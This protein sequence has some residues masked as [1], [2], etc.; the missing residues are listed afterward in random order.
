MPSSD[1]AALEGDRLLGPESESESECHSTSLFFRIAA[2]MFSFTVLGMMVST[3]GVMV[4]QF[5][6]YYHL[7]DLGVSFVFLV[8]PVGYV[9]AAY[10]NGAIHL[11]CGQRGIAAIGPL[12]HI[13]FTAAAVA[14]ALHPS[15]PVLLV[16]LATGSLGTGILD[17]SFC[18]WA[19]GMENANIVQGLL[20][21]S[22]SAGAAVGPFLAG[23]V[24][25]VGHLPWYTWYYV[26]LGASILEAV[27]LLLAFR[28]EDSEKCRNDHQQDRLLET[29]AETRPDTKTAIFKHSVTWI[30]A[31]YFLAYVGTENAISGWI[32]VFMQRVNHAS[33]YLASLSSSGFWIGQAAGRLVLGVV[34]DRIGVR[35]ATTVYLIAALAFELLFAAVHVPAVS[36]VTIALLGFCL[37]PLFPAGIFM[38]TRLLPRELH[39]EAISFVVLLGQIGGALLPFALG[40]LANTLGIRVFQVVVFAQLVATLLIWF[41]F[42]R[43]P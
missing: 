13:T 34:T 41:A 30:C 15:F 37:G 3:L 7:T 22:F 14:A 16:A 25:S 32:V 28:F 33:D 35:T 43:L 31:V 21:G 19:G 29:Q 40:A 12:F 9:A 20:H 10:L 26:L 24:L 6:N 2:S 42:P 39:V 18:A 38:M 11:R 17:G 27:I 36:T 1:D 5:E 4:P 23:T 8:W